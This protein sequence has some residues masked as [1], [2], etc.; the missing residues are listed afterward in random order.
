MNPWV[1]P[2]TPGSFTSTG[3]VS[4]YTWASKSRTFFEDY[5]GRVDQ[6][7]SSNLKVYG[8]YTYNHQ[9]GL[10]RPTSIAVPDFD[11]ANGIQPPFTQQNVS[12]GATKLF[13]P[14]ALND[15]RLGFYRVRN[16]TFVPSYNKDW[17]RQ[18]GI[19]NDSPLLL[20]SFSSAP[21]RPATG[22]APALNTAVRAHRGR[23]FPHSPRDPYVP[24]RFQQD[25]RHARFQ[26]GL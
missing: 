20:P 21:R 19:P 4:N 5:S 17:A 16:D 22:T 3:P 6:Q 14:T 18:L 7:F 24:R 25:R 8:S 23:A 1:P 2:N 12:A 26:N 13:G 9:S 11:G 10:Q 15:F